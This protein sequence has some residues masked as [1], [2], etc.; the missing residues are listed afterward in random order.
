MHVFLTWIC[1]G[2]RLPQVICS[3]FSKQ[4][5]SPLERCHLKGSSD[6][7]RRS[8]RRRIGESLFYVNAVSR[9]AHCAQTFECILAYLI[10][11]EILCQY[12]QPHVLADLPG[13]LQRIVDRGSNR[14][15]CQ[16]N[17]ICCIIKK[18]ICS[19]EFAQ[20]PLL[21]LT[22]L[23]AT[24]VID[25]PP[26]KHDLRSV[27]AD[28]KNDWVKLATAVQNFYGP[29]HAPASQYLRR[30]A[31]GFF[32]RTSIP[33][34]L[35]WL[36]VVDERAFPEPV[37]NLHK[38]ILDA[39]AP[40]AQLRAVWARPRQRWSWK[41]R[42]RC[43]RPIQFTPCWYFDIHIQS[44][45][46]KELDLNQSDSQDSNPSTSHSRGCSEHKIVFKN[47]THK[48]QIRHV[49]NFTFKRLLRAHFQESGHHLHREFRV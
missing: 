6:C 16:S 24:D 28:V 9:Q 36:T 46:R 17:D 35:P 4:G 21:V 49:F 8:S 20:K 48:I 34:Q 41:K 27:S 19:E 25:L 13:P 29:S 2:E 5:L 3:A 7:F 12:F 38:C 32:H 40:S 31:D 23:S 26:G 1:N 39:L 22:K 11:T 33:C 42:K 15:E 45:G 30:L 43:Q 14:R 47:Q 18:H 10:F 44:K 37:M